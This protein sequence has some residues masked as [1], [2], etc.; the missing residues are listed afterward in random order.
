MKKNFKLIF[1]SLL[2]LGLF[3]QI[4]IYS[5]AETEIEIDENC[6][7]TKRLYAPSAKFWE[8]DVRRSVNNALISGVISIYTNL[9]GID[10]DLT[11]MC[12]PYL[13][14][15]LPTKG[16]GSELKNSGI[17]TS[18]VLSQSQMDAM[19]PICDTLVSD[20]GANDVATGGG[21]TSLYQDSINSSLIGIGTMVEGAARKE[22]LP[23]NLAYYWNQ[24][25]EK[26]PFAGKALAAEGDAYENLPVVKAV[27]NIWKVSVEVALGLL[28]VILLYTGIM[29][30][31]GKKLSNQLVVSVQYAI[32][33]I[34]IGT[35][36]II[37]SYPIGAVI[38]SISFGLFRGAFPLVANLMY[39]QNSGELTSSGIL[40]L[41]ML[42]QVM[43]MA[44]GGTAHLL[45]AIIMLIIL[46]VTKILL[47]IKVLM[48]YIKMAFSIVTAP[49]EFVLGT[50]PGNDNK[51][52]DW[53]KRMLKY[54]L[55]LFGMG[56]V[57]PVTLYLSIEIMVV[58][59]SADASG[60]TGGWGTIISL[61][62]PI[63]ITV[64]GFGFGMG[65]EKKI[66]ELINGAGKKKK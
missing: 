41:T 59:M 43:E 3:F 52:T 27:Y 12:G 8:L 66:D 47:Y 26:I 22:P 64:F 28:S 7:V 23:V 53:F 1:I 16:Y 25:V 45:I 21:V 61:L 33:K 32:P 4:R 62:T 51:M 30:T 60:E 13:M 37:F 34:L 44:K 19:E 58:Y 39:G 9:A 11:A 48:V 36:L 63:L 15:K 50:V 14:D 10:P 40:M 54:G 2:F 31:M 6:S 56:V 20:L 49:L 42:V 18:C 24:S 29:I 46:T 65:M 55:T 35:V 57:I 17:L 38:T 5:R